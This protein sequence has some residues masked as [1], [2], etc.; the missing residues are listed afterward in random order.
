MPFA[1]QN[2][3]EGSAALDLEHTPR[4]LGLRSYLSSR[5]RECPLLWRVVRWMAKD[6][7]E[8]SQRLN[9]A[10]HATDRGTAQS[11]SASPL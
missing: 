8:R 6:A 11:R 3:M 2:L 9:P 10:P 4:S 5:I 7:H 1:T